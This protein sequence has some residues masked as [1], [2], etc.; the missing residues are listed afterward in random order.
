VTVQV[1]RRRVP[2]THPDKILFEPADGSAGA[3]I[4]KAGLADYYRLVADRMLPHLREHPLALQRFPDGTGGSGFFAKKVP[5]SAPDWVHTI[6]VDRVTGGSVTMLCADDVATLVYLADL[7]A[8]A[9][10]PW[11]SRAAAPRRP[12]KLIFDLDPPG[13]DDFPAVRRA[14]LALHELLTELDLPGYPMTTGSRG[15]HLVVPLA[16]KQD[17]DEVRAVA[18]AVADRLAA[19]YPEDL[20]T[21]VRKEQRHGRLFVDTLRNAYAQHAIAPYSPRPLPGAP[22]ATP[23]SWDEVADE[24]LT[25]ARR[26]RI[27]DLADRLSTVDDPWAGMGRHARD[28]GPVRRRLGEAG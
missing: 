7:A 13:G 20:T 12:V 6:T 8:L 2:L 21:Q 11:P 16:G 28:L 18:G 10:H 25:S 17:V 27:A 1:G 19:R 15:V 3:G 9:L 24:A 22:V 5:D 4:D 23:L 14:A 26:Y